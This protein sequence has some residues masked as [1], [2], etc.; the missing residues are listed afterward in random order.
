MVASSNGP[1][2]LGL[3]VCTVVFSLWLG[4]GRPQT[5]QGSFNDFSSGT[6]SSLLLTGEEASSCRIDR[7]TA[8]E[9]SVGLVA[10]SHS[11]VEHPD[12][13][14]LASV[15]ASAWEQWE[16]DGTS[17]DADSGIMI[18]FTRDPSYHFFGQGN[19][20]VEMFLMVNGRPVLQ[21]LDFVDESVVATCS[22]YIA[23]V[24]S[25]SGRQYRFDVLA[26]MSKATVR[27]TT[28]R[29]K[30]VLTIVSTTP[31][32]LAHGPIWPSHESSVRLSESLSSAQPIPGGRMSVEHH[33]VSGEA[34]FSGGG[35]H[36]R[37]WATDG[38]FNLA[39]GFNQIRAV[40]GPYALSYWQHEPRGHAS[41]N[42]TI[43]SA[44]LYRDGMLVMST[45]QGDA[46]AVGV[47]HVLFAAHFSGHVTGSGAPGVA[48][49]VIVFVSPQRNMTWRFNIAHKRRQFD[50]T[51]GY[52]KGL[53]GFAASV[54]G[55]EDG[56]NAEHGSAFV[57]HTDFPLEFKQWQIWAVYAVHTLGTWWK[58]LQGA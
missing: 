25:A 56:Q 28:K 47:D 22:G 49:R 41:A 45:D 17:D 39:G 19:L 38:W 7:R 37:L 24:W 48:A 54:V 3:A 46:A 16:F 12:I 15:N 2:W 5:G 55:G 27:W 29:S 53:S 13:P 35:G 42:R 43:Y 34:T 52:G 11:P 58:R 40:A 31:T 20:R 33:D 8:F 6:S 32:H 50:M 18:N 44:Q 23:G 10:L 9:Q 51:L 36:T 21:E 1:L 14:K 26:D 30:G 57:E 4:T